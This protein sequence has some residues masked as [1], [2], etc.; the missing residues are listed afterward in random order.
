MDIVSLIKI[1]DIT[2]QEKHADK[3][4]G[5]AIDMPDKQH[6]TYVLEIRGWVLGKVKPVKAIIITDEID[7]ESNQFSLHVPRPDVATHYPHVSYAPISGF[8]GFVNLL[9]MPLKTKLNVLVVLEDDSQL[10]IAVIFLQRKAIIQSNLNILQPALVS[11]IG[12]TGTTWLMRLLSEHPH[13]ATFKHYPYESKIASYWIHNVL[14][15]HDHNIIS[16]DFQTARFTQNQDWINSYLCNQPNQFHWFRKTYIEQLVDFCKQSIDNCFLELA[17]HDNRDLLSL[18][19]TEKPLYFAEKVGPGYI[20]DLL[21]EIYPKAR[22]II[23]VRDFRDMICSIKSFTQQRPETAQ[24]FGA[25]PDNE[26]AAFLEYTAHRV[27]RLA[28]AWQ[29]RK[30]RAYLLHYEDLILEPQK[31]LSIILDYLQLDNSPMMVQQLL[32]DAT[33]DHNQLMQKHRTSVDVKSSIGRWRQDLTP[34]QQA[35]VNDKFGIYLEMFGYDL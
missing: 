28:S 11:S 35:L 34:A 20:P 26:E 3:L 4:W 22:E 17:R 9:G 2:Y 33:Q 24:G 12:R 18:K 23:L 7:R 16:F 19:S 6:D 29:Q 21:Q 27:D 1:Q 15:A 31:T 8:H 30:N 32:R 25:N 14:K 10:K 5:Y 13:I